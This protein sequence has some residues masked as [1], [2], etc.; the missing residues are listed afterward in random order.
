YICGNV[1]GGNETIFNFVRRLAVRLNRNAFD[2]KEETTTKAPIAPNDRG[3]RYT[4]I[5]GLQ[6]MVRHKRPSRG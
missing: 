1:V 4:S 6:P 2:G 5:Y 3:P